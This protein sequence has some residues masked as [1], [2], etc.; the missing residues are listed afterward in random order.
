[1][2]RQF[3]ERRRKVMKGVALAKQT[4][5]HTLHNMTSMF[6]PFDLPESITLL[7]TDALSAPANFLLHRTLA[8]YIKKDRKD[9]DAVKCIIL[10]VSEDITRWKAIATKSVI[11]IFILFLSAFSEFTVKK[12]N[13]MKVFF[14]ISICSI[15]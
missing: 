4:R 6:S 13:K 10:S 11:I 9:K 15:V 12:N 7:I 5:R 14:R 8:A 3:A 2:R 1:M